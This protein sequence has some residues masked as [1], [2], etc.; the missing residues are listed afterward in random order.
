MLAA[1]ATQ[2]HPLFVFLHFSPYFALPSISLEALGIAF[3]TDSLSL[4]YL[5]AMSWW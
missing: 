4:N 3:Y 2:L 5:S 1:Y